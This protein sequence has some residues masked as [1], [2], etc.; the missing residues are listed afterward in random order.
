[1]TRLE[2]VALQS[3]RGNELLEHAIEGSTYLYRWNAKAPHDAVNTNTL[4]SYYNCEDSTCLASLTYKVCKSTGGVQKTSGRYAHSCCPDASSVT[5]RRAMQH[6]RNR[7]ADSSV[8]T[9]DEAYSAGVDM[10]LSSGL[11][12]TERAQFPTLLNVRRTL[13]R[14]VHNRLGN[15]PHRMSELT[16][17]PENLCRTE[18]GEPF[19]LAFEEYNDTDGTIGPIIMY[20]TKQDLIELYDS[21]HLAGDGTFKIKPYPYASKTRSQVFTLNTFDRST[22]GTRHARLRRRV[23]VLLPARTECCY[24]KMFEILFRKAEQLYGLDKINICWKKLMVDF[25]PAIANAVLSFNF[26]S[27]RNTIESQSLLSYL[28]IIPFF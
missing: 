7:A 19:L 27:F 11:N 21:A 1:M 28:I 24:R 17:I 2:D 16:H 6:V 22:L 15:P 10:I 23:L 26:V 5:V 13:N 14:I 12:R 25:E 4:N 20:A 18:E 8:N 9:A 3:Q